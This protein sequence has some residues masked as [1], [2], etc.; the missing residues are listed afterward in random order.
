MGRQTR[1]HRLAL[2]GVCG[3]DDETRGGQ[4]VFPFRNALLLRLACTEGRD[5]QK[6]P[7]QR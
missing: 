7:K 1:Q 6:Q 2:R 5:P 4:V 3:S